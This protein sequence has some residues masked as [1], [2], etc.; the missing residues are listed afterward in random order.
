[1]TVTSSQILDILALAVKQY[2]VYGKRGIEWTFD[3]MSSDERIAFDFF[4]VKMG[5]QLAYQP[6]TTEYRFTARV[7]AMANNL[8]LPE[9]LTKAKE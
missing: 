3:H 5:D 4:L 1:M 2:K 6:G 8:P 9:A 7:L